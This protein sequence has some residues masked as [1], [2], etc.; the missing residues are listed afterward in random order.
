MNVIDSLKVFVTSVK[1]FY[2]FN[3]LLSNFVQTDFF[4]RRK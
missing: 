3:M 4:I 1:L 2:T